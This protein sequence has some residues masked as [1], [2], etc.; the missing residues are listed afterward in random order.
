MNI[1]NKNPTSSLLQTLQQFVHHIQF[2]AI[3]NQVLSQ[4]I[5]QTILNSFEQARMPTAFPELHDNVKHGCSVHACG[6]S[7]GVESPPDGVDLLQ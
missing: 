4:Q 5:Q 7:P 1:C 3:I 2:T 6:V